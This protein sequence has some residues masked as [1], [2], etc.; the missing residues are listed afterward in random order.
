MNIQNSYELLEKIKIIFFD[1]DGVFMDNY[2]YVDSNGTETVKCSRFD[3][4]GQSA[5]GDIGIDNFILSTECNNVVAKRAEKLKIKY[6]KCTDNKLE[7]I[8]KFARIKIF[9]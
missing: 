5:L 2:V 9:Y 4:F 6:F 1:F 7:F 3:G 8:K